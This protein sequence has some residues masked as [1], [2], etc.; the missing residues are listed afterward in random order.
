VLPHWPKELC[1]WNSDCET[2][3]QGWY[4]YN[5]RE[6]WAKFVSLKLNRKACLYEYEKYVIRIEVGA[7]DV[8]MRALDCPRTPTK[9]ND[10]WDLCLRNAVRPH[11]T[12]Q[13]HYIFANE[14]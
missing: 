4:H 12:K 3:C 1:R 10:G 7:M 8:H 2:T 13:H 5:K 6:I 11:D 9:K 14:F